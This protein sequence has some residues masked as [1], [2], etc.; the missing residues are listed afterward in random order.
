MGQT[1]QQILAEI[2]NRLEVCEK[3]LDKH[4]KIAENHQEAL[5]VIAETPNPKRG[6]KVPLTPLPETLESLEIGRHPKG[7]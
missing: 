4:Q 6:V 7:T 3:R 2:R 1:L 5:E